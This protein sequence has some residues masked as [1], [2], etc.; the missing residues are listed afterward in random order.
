MVKGRF[1]SSSERWR[2]SARLLLRAGSLAFGLGA[3]VFLSWGCAG[4][5]T[6]THANLSDSI[7]VQTVSRRDFSQLVP[8]L[9]RVESTRAVRVVAL[10]AGRVEEVL[11]PDGSTVKRGVPIFRM[12]GPAL[13]PA[14]SAAR[15]S[16]AGLQARLSLAEGVVKLKEEAVRDRIADESALASARSERERLQAD[17]AQARSRLSLLEAQ[18]VV[19]SPA[20]GVFTDRTV[21]PGQDV[22]PGMGLAEVVDSSSLRIAA[23]LFPPAGT[24]LLEC[25]ASVDTG[26]KNLDAH[27]SRVFPDRTA[28]GGIRVWI[29]GRSLAPALGP[30]SA[31]SG[32]VTLARHKGVLAVPDSA[33]VYDDQERPYIFLD[34]AGTYAK[35]S[36]TLGLTSPGWTEV[37]SGL[38]DGDRLVVE[39]AYELYYRDYG[40]T[41]KVED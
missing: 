39:G 40:R 4:R 1:Q 26:T 2:R 37:T 34:R 41:H 28:A 24:R 14:L 17:L 11:V 15:A 23:T 33:L 13:T 5:D 6:E 10:E 8:W 20:D 16:V 9:G 22:S 12:G 21:N 31:A 32:T 35:T 27:V 29:E 19:L 30:G 18:S 38:K 7:R 3:V 25:P 36:V